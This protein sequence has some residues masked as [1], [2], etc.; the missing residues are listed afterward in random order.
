MDY[1][2]KETQSREFVDC[3]KELKNKYPKTWEEDYKNCIIYAE[4]ELRD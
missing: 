1:V 4:A 2:A 3:L